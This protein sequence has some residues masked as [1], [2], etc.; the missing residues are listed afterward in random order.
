MENRINELLQAISNNDR[1]NGCVFWG[2]GI[3]FVIGNGKLWEISDDASCSPKGGWFPDIVTGPTDEE[4]KCLTA[5]MESLNFGKDFFR[6][7]VDDYGEFDAEYVEEYFEDNEDEDSLKIYRKIKK[8]IDGGKIPFATVNDFAS[9]LMRYGLD[10]NCLYYEWEGEFIDLHDN[11][12]ET[13]NERGSYDSLSDAEW[14]E[15][16]ENIDKY[17]LP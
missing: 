8:K 9:A 16:L 11:I 6:E 12:A 13:G 17:I 4:D 10:N 2:R 3:Y 5:L 14:I 7:L 15:L 1:Y